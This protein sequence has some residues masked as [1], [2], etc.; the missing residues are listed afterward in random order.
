MN[1]VALED[2][3]KKRKRKIV[4]IQGLKPAAGLVP[5]VFNNKIY[6]LLTKRAAHLNHH[7]GEISFPGGRIEGEDV[8]VEVTAIRETEEE[9]GIKK[10][11]IIILG[12][13]DDVVSVT[14]FRL[15]PFVGI[16][17]YKSHYSFD[18]NEVEQVYL[19]PISSFLVTPKVI[20]YKW[21]GEDKPSYVYDYKDIRIFGVTANV[22]KNFITILDDSGFIELNKEFIF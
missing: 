19:I 13:I 14:K 17:P 11:E 2:F 15:T 22:I 21:K 4:S 1:Y 20:N 10:E 3:L 5:L 6:M 7:P 18:K 16:V 9:V 12:A 8:S